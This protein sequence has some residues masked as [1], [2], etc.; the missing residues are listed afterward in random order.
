MRFKSHNIALGGLTLLGLMFS[1][2]ALAHTGDL[3]AGLLTGLLHPLTG[4]DHLLMIILIAIYTAQTS[5]RQRFSL[6]CVLL[7][8]LAT[9]ALLGANA[10]S[11]D[12]VETGIAISLLGLGLL[13]ML[14]RATTSILGDGHRYSCR[15]D[16]WPGSWIRNTRGYRGTDIY[17]WLSDYQCRSP[18]YLYLARALHSPW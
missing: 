2:V 12:A 8:T 7:I 17:S 15:P 5:F 18:D 1:Q 3:A 4:I 14:P 13:L 11:V 16:A 10:F 9:G 6:P